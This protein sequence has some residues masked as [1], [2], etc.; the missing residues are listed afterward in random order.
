MDYAPAEHHGDTQPNNAFSFTWV[1]ITWDIIVMVP[2]ILLWYFGF[3][4]L[5]GDIIP[6]TGPGPRRRHRLRL[7]SEERALLTH[8]RPHRHS[9]RPSDQAELEDMIDHEFIVMA[10]EWEND[11]REARR[12]A[13][14]ERVRRF[15]AQVRSSV[16]GMRSSFTAATGTGSENHERETERETQTDL[17]A[18]IAVSTL[19]VR[20]SLQH[21]QQ[22]QRRQLSHGGHLDVNRQG[23]EIQLPHRPRPSAVDCN[24]PL[25]P[26]PASRCVASLTLSLLRYCPWYSSVNAR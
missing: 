25:P 23:D 7:T 15:N 20:S 2:M 24:Q 4:T 5:E 8:P 17:E 10:R 13:R 11:L 26:L 3:L 1:I 22:Y 12:L 14:Q 21:Q 19:P 6:R 18:G 16:A 9:R